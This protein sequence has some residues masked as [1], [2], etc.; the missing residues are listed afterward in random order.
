MDE[1]VEKYQDS[2]HAIEYEIVMFYDDNPEM[3][4]YTVMRSLEALMD[5]YVAKKIG[6][7]PRDFSLDEMEL[8]LVACLIS[9]SDILIN[10]ASNP[11][12]PPGTNPLSIDEILACLKRILKSV[13]MW[14]KNE[15]K[16]GYL[17]F[18]SK[19]V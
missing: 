9:A 19:Y 8:E 11:D 15:G 10:P 2:L 6:R 4:D 18:V 3:S 1:I 13:K 17:D 5:H 7:S 12:V 14:N 16:R